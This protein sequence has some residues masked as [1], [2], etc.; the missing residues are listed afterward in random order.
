[1]RIQGHPIFISLFWAMYVMLMYQHTMFEVRLE[2][3]TPH[4]VC[5][6]EKVARR[7]IQI[8]ETYIYTTHYFIHL[9]II[10]QFR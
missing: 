1:M 2:I 10:V 9:C 5:Q 4:S 8:Y 3:K 6:G 7:T